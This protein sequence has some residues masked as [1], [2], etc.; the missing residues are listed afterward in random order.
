MSAVPSWWPDWR[1][2]TCVIVAS[3]PSAKGCNLAAARGLAKFISVNDSWSLAPWS[4]ALY[5]CDCNWWRAAAGAPGFGG[6]KISQDDKC[7]RFFPDVKVVRCEK[8]YGV[9]SKLL[10]GKL[11]LIGWASNGGFQA[12]NLAVQFG[13][14][15]IIL[16]GYDMRID[17]GLHWHGKHRAVV[18]LADGSQIR[19]KNPQGPQVARWRRAL[20]GAASVLDDLGVEVLNASPVSALTAYRKIHFAEAFA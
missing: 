8:S 15:R 11:G 10:V 9:D 7:P 5:G 4:D 3:G 6:L 20:D 1:D 13:S 19:L 2:E 17:L 12:L 18:D 16:V 14:K